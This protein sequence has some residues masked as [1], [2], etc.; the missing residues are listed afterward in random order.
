M[1]RYSENLQQKEMIER[2]SQLNKKTVLN[3]IN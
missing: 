3:K 1:K 2:N